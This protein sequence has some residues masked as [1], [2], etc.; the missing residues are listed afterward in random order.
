MPLWGINGALRDV[1]RGV[2]AGMR[3]APFR[4]GYWR[5]ANKR[6][7]DERPSLAIVTCIKNEGDDLVEWLCFH[8]QIGVSRFVIYDNLSTDAT[9]AILEAVPF[10]DE[11]VVH[12]MADPSPQKAAF[13]D[14]L[15]RY[16]DELDWVAF[17]D[18]D[19]FIVP[20]GEVSIV[21]KLAELEARGVDGFAIH[22]RIFGSAGHKERPPGLVTESFTRRAEDDFQP[23]R[24]VKSVVRIGK[25]Q[26]M[27][28]QHYFRVSGR[29]L[30]DDGTQAPPDF[31]GIASKASYGQGFAIHHYITKSHAQ[32]LQ[33][34][35]RGRPKPSGSKAKYRGRSYW[36]TYD[37]NAMPDDRA[38]EVIAPIRTSVLQLRQAIETRIRDDLRAAEPV[39]GDDRK[40]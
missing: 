11:I 30:L 2:S 19:E 14:A 18:G 37:R 40:L 29:Y 15:K 1:F 38:A 26:S 3:F 35:A 8:R 21:D 13:N 36:T 10:R 27:A 7:A 33:K 12:R 32:C 23:N 24:H 4:L 5:R 39:T 20:L 16:R 6:A 25:V 28:T 17:I 34:I 31:E 9:A 22:W